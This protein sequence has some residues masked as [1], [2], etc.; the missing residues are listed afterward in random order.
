MPD[1]F[2]SSRTLSDRLRRE[3]WF[4]EAPLAFVAWRIGETE[5]KVGRLLAEGNRVGAESERMHA[6]A[7]LIGGT[8]GAALA[9]FVFTPV[10][11]LWRARKP[12]GRQPNNDTGE[13]NWLIDSPEDRTPTGASHM[14]QGLDSGDPP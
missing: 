2:P 3:F 4:P 12:Q 10:R 1:I 6:C 9:L 5:H 7:P 11:R 13:I 8:V 14:L